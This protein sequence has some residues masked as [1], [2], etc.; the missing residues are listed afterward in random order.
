MIL[1]ELSEEDKLK[2]RL[3]NLSNF[4]RIF[5]ILHFIF[6]IYHLIYFILYYNVKKIILYVV[7]TFIITPIIFFSVKYFI[8]SINIL[9]E[10]YKICFVFIKHQLTMLFLLNE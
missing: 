4:I 10:I 3:Y 6:N 9:V 2:Y 7:H 5:N 8:F 1:T